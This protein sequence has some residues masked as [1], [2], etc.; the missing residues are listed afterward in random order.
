MVTTAS[1]RL[2]VVLTRRQV[3]SVEGRLT[4]LKPIFGAVSGCRSDHVVNIVYGKF[5]RKGVSNT[6]GELPESG[7][8]RIDDAGV[9]IWTHTHAEGIDHASRREWF[10]GGGNIRTNRVRSSFIPGQ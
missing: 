7:F 9:H 1:G 6:L 3:A 8:R 2:S 4:S 5:R 10:N